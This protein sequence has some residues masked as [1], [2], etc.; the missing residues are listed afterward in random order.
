MTLT[1]EIPEELE[2]E[3][4]T[5]ASRLGL[6]LVE[7]VVRILTAGRLGEIPKTGAELVAYWQKEG[8]IGSR[9]DISDSQQHARQ[10]RLEAEQRSRE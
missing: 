2:N 4:V 9:S 10:L 8:L 6:P 3:L 1:L 7:Y 5:E